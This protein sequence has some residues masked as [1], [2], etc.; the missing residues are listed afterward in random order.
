[1]SSFLIINGDDF[2]LTDSVSAA[3]IT[4]IEEGWLSS[5]SVMICVDGAESKVRGAVTKIA[6]CAGVHL[7]ITSGYPRLPRSR[8]PSLY[9]KNDVFLSQDQVGKMDPSEIEAEWDAQIQCAIDWGLKPTHLDSHHAV[10]LDFRILEVYLKLARKYSLP[11]RGGS[12]LA[13]KRMKENGVSGSTVI[14]Q[15]WT[16]T[17]G[18][19]E[20]LLHEIDLRLKNTTENDVIEVVSHPGFVDAE[21]RRIS[22]LNDARSMDVIG[23]RKLIASGELSKRGIELRSFSMLR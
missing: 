2:G 12:L 10:H 11:V 7:T 9:G 4:G 16:G 17:D 21:L 14:I 20:K 19:V 3:I 13:A 5:T 15:N 23:L 8:V 1:M 6:H 22:S 18:N